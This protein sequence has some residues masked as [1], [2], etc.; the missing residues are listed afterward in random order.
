M[1]LALLN[2]SIVTAYGTYEYQQI[3]LSRAKA[4]L[5]NSEIDSAIGHQSTADLMSELLGID[6]EVNKQQFQQSP[7]QLALVFKL[8]ERQPEGTVLSRDEI[9]K[10]GYTWGVLIRHS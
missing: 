9:E 7:G 4:L 1:K 2:T 8:N 10:I 6:V 3:S 5:V